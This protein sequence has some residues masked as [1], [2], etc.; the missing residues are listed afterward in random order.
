[1]HLGQPIDL[2]SGAGGWE[3]AARELGIDT[4]GI[5]LDG[6]PFA[7]ARAAGFSVLQAD[8]AALEALDFAP[9][10]G[11]IGSPPCPTFSSA[12]RGAGRELE[13]IIL[14]A[15]ADLAAGRDTREQRRREAY[16]GWRGRS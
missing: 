6:A 12:G 8:M 2:C 16:V 13:A 14:G 10:P 3:V 9:T 1:M 11:V 7:V 4:L 15:I 5:E